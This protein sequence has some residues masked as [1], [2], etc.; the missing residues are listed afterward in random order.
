M[1]KQQI[2]R[3]TVY[4]QDEPVACGV[5][6]AD[7]EHK[8]QYAAQLTPIAKIEGATTQ[9]CWRKAYQLTRLPVIE[10]RKV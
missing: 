5:S 9:E 7:G 3:A 10:W 6:I 2:I 1:T 4:R 8:T